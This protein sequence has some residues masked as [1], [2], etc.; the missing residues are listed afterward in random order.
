MIPSI[1]Q[2]AFIALSICIS[3]STIYS[4]GLEI[5]GMI[6]DEQNEA[7]AFANVLL[8]SYPDSVYLHGTV[9]DL[10]GN[11]S[12][13]GLYFDHTYIV[14]VQFIGFAPYFTESLNYGDSSDFQPLIITLK[15]LSHILDGVTISD[16]KSL[17]EHHIDKVVV[18]VEGNSLSAGSTALEL[19]EKSPG[20]SVD[21]QNENIK[22]LS[23]TGV[24]IYING[25]QNY[26]SGNDLFEYFRSLN[27]DQISRIEIISNPSSKHDAAGNSGIINIILKKDGALGTNGSVAFGAGRGF[28]PNSRDDL[29]RGSVST[30]LNH[31]SGKLYLHSSL[32][33]LTDA[34]YSENNIFRT[35][36]FNNEISSFDQRIQKFP[37]AQNLTL[38]MGVDYFLSKKTTV[39]V[40]IDLNL[41]TIKIDGVNATDVVQPNGEA[42]DFS[43]IQT[44]NQKSPRNNVNTNLNLKHDFNSK[45][46]TLYFDVDYLKYHFSSEQNFN[47]RFIFEE[48]V[49]DSYLLQKSDNTSSLSVLATK[50]DFSLPLNERTKF[51]VGLK[52]SF[53]GIDSQLKFQ[54]F[55]NDSWAIDTTKSNHFLYDEYINALYGS[56]QHLISKFSFQLGVRAE[57]TNSVGNSVTLSNLVRRNYIS[58]FPSAFVTY[59]HSD[60]Q[61]FKFAYSRRLDRPRY[62]QLNPFII[63][64]DPY[65]YATGNPYLRPQF[66]NS[67]ELGYYFKSYSLTVNYALTSDLITELT[68]PND[69]TRITRTVETN[70]RNVDDF[71]ISLNVN[72][73]VKKFWQIYFQAIMFN[74]HFSDESLLD[75]NLDVSQWM[76]YA[77]ISN[78]FKLPGSIGLELSGWY[79]SPIVE[80]IIVGKNHRFSVNVGAQK[81]FF[82]EKVRVKA[83]VTDLFLTSFIDGYVDY[84]NVQL[85]FNP[86]FNTRRIMLSISY[87][88]GSQK[89]KSS[90][91]GRSAAETEKLRISE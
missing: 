30:M 34:S 82:N 28:L 38:R 76:T 68:I 17:V 21:Y 80:G 88:I 50:L 41:L 71:S 22:M 59:E 90:Q 54:E 35:F 86:R 31:R 10:I 47:A 67:F 65:S 75:G 70:L 1:L 3:G 78:N 84:Q 64:L 27:S 73:S 8:L 15:S 81:L 51:E 85:T 23:K 79:Q 55:M 48:L 58:L 49:T 20:V 63:V 11:F 66:T 53:V 24:I 36:T 4:Q 52:S 37:D 12:F 45:G 74:K 87:A 57:N 91:Q 29:N 62:D 83:N 26:L 6:K 19:L 44:V 39:G 46:K 7:V 16:S 13:G 42:N 9:S 32:N 43:I 77:Y 2:R 25:R 89:I 33:I 40:G 5:S 60:N 61:T 72:H 18:N 56:F 14:K 69:S